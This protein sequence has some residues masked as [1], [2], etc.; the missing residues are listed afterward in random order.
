MA[1]CSGLGTD[2]ARSLSSFISSGAPEG[3]RVDVAYTMV[4]PAAVHSVQVVVEVHTDADVRHRSRQVRHPL[5][6][7]LAQIRRGE[8][9]DF[10]RCS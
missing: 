10:A 7:E 9:V 5:N 6:D 2:L 3:S 1:A 4:W 8:F